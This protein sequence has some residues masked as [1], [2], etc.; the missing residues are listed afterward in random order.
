MRGPRLW[1]MV[2]PFLLL[3]AGLVACGGGAPE[4]ESGAAAD[5]GAASPPSLLSLPLPRVLPGT[6]PTG[7]TGLRYE[8]RHLYPVLEEIRDLAEALKK[9]QG[10]ATGA[11]RKRQKEEK[12]QKR[13]SR[14][15]L[16][17]SLPEGARPS[18]LA[19][20]TILPHRPP[21]AQFYTGTCWSFAATSL[22]E[23]EVQ[24][25]TGRA[26]KLS[27][28]ATVFY[29]YLEKA[30]RFVAERGDSAFGQGSQAGAVTRIWSRYGAW[31][32]DAYPGAVGE[33]ARHDHLR[34]FRD[35]EGLLGHA[36]ASDQWDEA[37]VRAMLQVV[38][39]RHMGRPPESFSFDGRSYRS[40]EFMRGAL[41]IEPTDYVSVMS[42]MRAPFFTQAEFEVPDNWAHEA[43]YHNVPLDLFYSALKKALQRGF[44][45]VIA[46]DT[47]EPGKDAENDVLYVPRYDLPEELIDQ[48]A[49]E[50]R[51][52]SK[53]TTDDHGIHVV[54]YT[55]HDGH[56]WFLAKDSGRSA[57]RG[58]HQGYYF[59][60][61]DYIRLKVL[62]WMVHRAAIPELLARFAA[63]E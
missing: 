10:E 61:E 52:E 50:Y 27:E 37:T 6:G 5:G 18:S 4:E 53:V 17:S 62:A 9:A 49:R 16:Q 39:E 40:E 28:M 20:F 35:L 33:D 22:L 54:G 55:H 56:D 19:A 36:K 14:L 30:A 1:R 8:T 57:R 25:I 46:L 29:E 48:A 3:L 15:V 24:R 60:R 59:V 44:T 43:D 11:I 13:K 34:M 31:P 42:T 32:H 26:V 23:S 51:I 2:L 7:A 41:Q 45:A 58:P 63:P 21:T 47:S 12:E 38:L